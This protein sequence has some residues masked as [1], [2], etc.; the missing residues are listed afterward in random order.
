MNRSPRALAAPAAAA[1]LFC[2]L[3]SRDALAA[4]APRTQTLSYGRFGEVT[5]YQPENSRHLVLFVSG[6]GGWNLGVVGM[7]KSLAGLDATVVGIDI[8][9]YEKAIASA[10][11]ECTNAASDFAAL[12]TVVEEKLGLA[13]RTRPIL[14]GY[15]SGATLVYAILVQARPDTFGG[16]L[17]LGF[18]PDLDLKKPMC[19]GHGLTF[20]TLPK[21]K[22]YLFDPA[23]TLENPFIAFQ[24]DADQVCDPQRT[25]AYTRKVRKGE[26]VW[27]PKVGHGFSSERRWL[28]QFKDA[29]FR[30]TGA[31]K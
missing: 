29:F 16:A 31:A 13:L 26:L 12:A 19:K 14:A 1:L 5:V 23:E 27:L 18:C 10:S 15:S 17:A 6:D 7:A 28:P 20:T 25:A 3:F 24:G 30:L 9:R 21:G 22:G 11:D 8:R 4:E 2:A